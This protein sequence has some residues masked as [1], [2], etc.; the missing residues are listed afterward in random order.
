MS[1]NGWLIYRPWCANAQ[2]EINHS[3]QIYSC[4]LWRRSWMV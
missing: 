3:M 1:V 4:W 2:S